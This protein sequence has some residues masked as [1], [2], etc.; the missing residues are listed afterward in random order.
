MEVTGLC[1]GLYKF[2]MSPLHRFKYA[3]VIAVQ[4]SIGFIFL[5]NRT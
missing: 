4:N 2:N 5:H 1:L 3:Q